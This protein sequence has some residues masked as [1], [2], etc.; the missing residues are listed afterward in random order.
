MF[1]SSSSDEDNSW[2]DVLLQISQKI[3]FILLISNS[4]SDYEAKDNI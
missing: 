4:F 1:N 2:E 3:W